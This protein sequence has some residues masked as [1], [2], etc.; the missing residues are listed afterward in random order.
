MI[1]NCFFFEEKLALMTF[2]P[3]WRTGF[4]LQEKCKSVWHTLEKSEMSKFRHKSF[5]KFV[6]YF[7][8]FMKLRK[9]RISQ[10]CLDR[11]VLR[12]KVQFYSFSAKVFSWHFITITFFIKVRSRVLQKHKNSIVFILNKKFQ[13]LI[14]TFLTNILLL[15]Q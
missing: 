13:T 6:R 2:W 10:L 14:K 1:T 8:H 7:R 5:L 4:R 11:T 9:Y 3:F 12:L 15:Q